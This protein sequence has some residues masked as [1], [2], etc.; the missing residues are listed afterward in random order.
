MQTYHVES[1]FQGG[2]TRKR[3]STRYLVVHH[4]GLNSW[5]PN[6]ECGI[7][8]AHKCTRAAGNSRV[9][10][11]PVR[12]VIMGII[13]R[14]SGIY[15]ILCVSTGKVY[16]GSAIDLRRRYQQHW[17]DLRLRRHKNSLLQ[18]AWNKYGEDSFVFSVLE[19]VEPADLI[20]TEQHYL[21]T[22]QS[23][24]RAVGFNLNPVAG[25]RL[26]SH[27]SPEAIEKSR[28]ANLGREHSPEERAQRRASL[29]G[30]VITW[31]EKIAD[32]KRG[33]PRD[34]ATR[35][36]LSAANLGKKHP[37]E[38]YRNHVRQYVLT[39]P[40]GEEFIITNLEAYCRDVLNIDPNYMRRV[41]RGARPHHRGWK[42]RR[43]EGDE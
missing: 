34:D 9:L 6:A 13:P 24:D 15:Q 36:K 18:R 40:S 12:E 26:G 31:G 2:Y 22:L 14:S 30:R 19:Q 16:I 33:K 17:S 37:A 11:Q 10:G 35:S 32:A 25:S 8:Q 1:E 43:L 3:T 4:D 28:R 41:V 20:A 39:S 27:Q 7:I 38:A 42:C 23:H 5:R 21:D 29:L